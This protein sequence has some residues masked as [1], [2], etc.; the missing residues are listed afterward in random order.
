MIE[1]LLDAFSGPGAPFMWA[2]TA[3]MAFAFAV[4]LER[5]WMLVWVWRSDLGGVR[6]AVERRDREAALGAAGKGPL[7]DVLTAGFGATDREVAWDAMGAAAAEAESRIDARI[8]YLAAVGN[9]A[10]M[11]GLLGTVYGLI[12][13]FSALGD[14]GAGERAVRLSEGISTAMATTAYGLCVG[15]PSLAAHTWL[16]AR[17]RRL[18]SGIESVAGRLVARI[19]G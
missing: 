7:A 4:F 15:I 13:A 17:A 8:P 10:T 3:V 16:E 18:I 12:L 6:A 2:I 9:V 14:T 11:I 1:Y 5:A 19:G